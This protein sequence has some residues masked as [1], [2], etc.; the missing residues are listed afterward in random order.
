MLFEKGL[1]G[2][3]QIVSSIFLNF[4][5]FS[6]L[7]CLVLLHSFVRWRVRDEEE[8]YAIKFSEIIKKEGAPDEPSQQA[9]EAGKQG[10]R[11]GTKN[12]NHE[13]LCV[14]FCLEKMFFLLFSFLLG[15]KHAVSV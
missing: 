4:S 10:R 8:S 14:L 7:A 15:M 5:F 6:V 3:L 11:E 2:S 9:S 1:A 13:F 12:K